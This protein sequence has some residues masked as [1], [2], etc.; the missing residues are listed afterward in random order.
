MAQPFDPGTLRRSGEAF[1]VA[2]PVGVDSFQRARFSVSS[3]GVIVYDSIVNK[4][5]LRWFDRSGKPLES[6]GHPGEY[7]GLN[8]SPDGRTV[9]ADLKGDVW[10]FNL[11]R[12]GV[13]RF[14][15]N[16]ALDAAGSWSSDGSRIVFT[17]TR[18]RQVSLYEKLS[19]GAGEEKLL[20][21]GKGFIIANGW[22]P[23]GRF[24]L[25][26]ENDAKTGWDLWALSL[27]GERKS[28]PIQRTGF[29]EH[30]GEFSPD[31]KWIAY[32]SN[33]SGRDEVFVR[34]FSPAQREGG[35]KWQ[36]SMGGGFM[37]KWRAD[38][39]EIFFL[40]QDRH[41]MVAAV[42]TGPESSGTFQAGAPRELFPTNAFMGN[43]SMYSVTADGQRFLINQDVENAPQSLAT[44]V[45][46]WNSTPKK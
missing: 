29:N 44:V 23:D 33:E 28:W 3:N 25:Y 15:V 9:A 6:V 16:P 41:M 27:E 38:G 18:D 11:T 13:S 31:G 8:I 19:N 22:S 36:V 30:W 17:S 20:L 12:G 45:V 14:T 39:T 7:V 21:K 24:L 32:V 37:P 43:F 10:L 1:P 35:A 34:A 40:G 26:S 4:R 2:G 42:E 46:N 5:E